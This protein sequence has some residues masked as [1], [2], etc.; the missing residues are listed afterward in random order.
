MPD[1]PL[2]PPEL[3]LRHAAFVRAVARGALGG[4]D[5][6]EDV[7]Q[8]TWLAALRGG[9]ERARKLRPWLGSVAYRRAK[10]MLRRRASER[11]RLRGVGSPG[12]APAASDA[13]VRAETSRRLVAAVLALEEPYRTAVLLRPWHRPGTL[14]RHAR[15]PVGDAATASAITCRG[16]RTRGG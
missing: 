14:V 3:L 2:P 12:A 10:D 5:L 11:R 6:V 7:V 4:D 8:E 9:V 13:V 1:R 16:T 15:P